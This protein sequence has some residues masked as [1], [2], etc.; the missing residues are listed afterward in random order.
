MMKGLEDISEKRYNG[1]FVDL[2]VRSSNVVAVEMYKKMGYV[3]YRRVL[4]YYSGK[5]SED[6]FGKIFDYI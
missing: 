5:P 6:A 2:F 4:G 3:I 1:F